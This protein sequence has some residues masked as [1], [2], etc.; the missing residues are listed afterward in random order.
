MPNNH[1]KR[2]LFETLKNHLPSK[3]ISLIVGA[4]QAGKTT[5]MKELIS[6]VQKTGEKTIFLNLDYES[7]KIYLETQDSLLNKLRLEFGANRGYVFIDEIQRKKN[8]GLFL[9]GLYDLDLP[10]KLIV[11][12]SGSLE[13]KE[14]IHESLA[15]R[16]RLFELSP[17]SFQEFVNFKTDY[18]YEQKLEEF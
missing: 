3:E 5:L 8:A 6:Y 16:K 18:R 9:K 14:K 7:D 17:L 13:L 15:G 2:R 11:S 12:G 10:Y 4:R 1:I